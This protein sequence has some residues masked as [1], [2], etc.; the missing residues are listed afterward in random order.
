MAPN[1][2]VVYGTW[3]GFSESLE[4]HDISISIN[5]LDNMKIYLVGTSDSSW[6]CGLQYPFFQGPFP[7]GEKA[8]FVA[9]LD[10]FPLSPEYNGNS[11]CLCSKPSVI[12]SS[13]FLTDTGGAANTIS[14]N[15]S[16]VFVAGY[17]TDFDH[18]YQT[19]NT[20]QIGP[21]GN[22]GATLVAFNCRKF[23]E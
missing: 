9:V 18:F 10:P 22:R 1:D 8:A 17:T 21:S 12:V 15:A 4:I 19:I 5:S 13:T 16:C 6:E 11:K 14:L 3:I 2:T 7:A 20:S 23:Q